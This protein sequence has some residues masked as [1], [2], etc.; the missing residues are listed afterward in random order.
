MRRLPK[1]EII[2]SANDRFLRKS[3]LQGFV[4]DECAAFQGGVGGNAGLFS[5][6]REIARIYQMLLNEGEL[7]G[8]RY[9]SRETWK[10]FTTEVS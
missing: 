1:S 3:V 6:A 8:H 5:N 2:P 9:L 4:H 10:L 7:D